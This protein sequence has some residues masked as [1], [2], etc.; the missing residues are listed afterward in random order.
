MKKIFEGLVIIVILCVSSWVAY[1]AG[2]VTRLAKTPRP[3]E[4]RT[5]VIPGIQQLVRAGTSSLG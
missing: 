5:P 2:W 1:R 3:P 4:A